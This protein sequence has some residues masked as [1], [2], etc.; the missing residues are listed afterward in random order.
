MDIRVNPKHFSRVRRALERSTKVRHDA[1]TINPDPAVENAVMVVKDGRGQLVE[2][3]RG[4]D[5]TLSFLEFGYVRIRKACPFRHRRCIGEKCALYVVRRD[6]GDCA[7]IWAV[8]PPIT[9]LK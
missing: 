5:H 1:I 8:V 6:V 7:Q 9:A 2:W 3:F 4:L